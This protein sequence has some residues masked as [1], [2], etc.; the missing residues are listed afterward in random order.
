MPRSSSAFCSWPKSAKAQRSTSCGSPFSPVL[1]PISSRPWSI[2]SSSSSSWSMPAGFRRKTPICLN[3]KPTLPVLPRLPPPL[4]KWVRTL[5]TVRVGLSVAVSTMTRDAVRRVALVE[6]LLVVRRV[7]ARG[8]LDRRLDLVLRHV[9][10]A[11]VLDRR[12]AARD[13]TSGS[14]PPALTAMVISL[15]IRANGF[16]MRSQRA[17]IVCFLVS[18]MRP[19]RACCPGACQTSSCAAAAMAGSVTSGAGSERSAVGPTA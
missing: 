8:A 10:R 12:A 5:A 18:K 15:P 9:D 1:S 14:G 19:M 13:W 11:R 7:L 2:S 6:D 16:A 3:R 4:L 17:N